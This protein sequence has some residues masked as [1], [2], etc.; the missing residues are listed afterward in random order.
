M[1]GLD[2]LRALREHDPAFAERFV[3]MTGSVDARFPD[4][5]VV[6][7][8]IDPKVVNELLAGRYNRKQANVA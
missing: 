8:P 7:K 2:F 6:N 5:L 1:S 3:I 4:V